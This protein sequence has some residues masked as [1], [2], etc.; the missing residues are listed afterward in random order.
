[1]AVVNASHFTDYIS[2]M[3]GSFIHK[4]IF[5]IATILFILYPSFNIIYIESWQ[6]SIINW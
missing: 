1:M 4:A 2:K 5:F 6:F 3:I